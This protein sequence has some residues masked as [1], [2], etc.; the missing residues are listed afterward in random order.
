MTTGPEFKLKEQCD[1]QIKQ[2]ILQENY[3]VFLHVSLQF[4]KLQYIMRWMWLVITSIK[5]MFKVKEN[6]IENTGV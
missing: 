1:L 6:R 5:T 2:V 3:T 4:I